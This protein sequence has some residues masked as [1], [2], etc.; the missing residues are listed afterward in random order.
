ME[1][2]EPLTNAE[3]LLLT[4]V[5][6]GDTCDF[7]GG[8]VI[9]STEVAEWGDDRRIRG[10]VLKEL[11][12]G[13]NR[14]GVPAGT[15]I[16]LRGAVVAGDLFGFDGKTLPE[17]GMEYCRFDGWVSFDGAIF[18]GQAGFGCA[19]FS[20]DV[21]FDGTL[22]KGDVSFNGATFSGDT[23][24]DGATFNGRAYFTNATFD[25]E[26]WLKITTFTGWAT[27]DEVTFNG[28]AWFDRAI[29]AGDA[30]FKEAMFAR[31]ASFFGA[32]V[33]DDARFDGATFT[34]RADF[35]RA[36]A[37]EWNLESVTFLAPDPGPWF[38]FTVLINRATVTVR[39]RI[40]IT[41]RKIDAAWLQAPDGAHLL[42]QSQEVDLSD[43]EFLRR[44]IIAGPAATQ[45][46]RPVQHG[47]GLDE[48]PAAIARRA[49]AAAANERSAER[50][51]ELAGSPRR[52]R[53]TSLAR[54]N[55]GE[56]V[57]SDVALDECEFAGA[58]GLDRLR[59]DEGCSFQR[60]PRWFTRRRMIVEEIRWR[61]SH[62]RVGNNASTIEAAPLSALEIAGIYR[63]LRKGLEDSKNEPEAADF[64]YGEM[65][66]RRLVGRKPSAVGADGTRERRSLVEGALLGGYWALSGYGLRAWRA[67]TALTMLI[68]VAA[69]LYTSPTFAF[70]TPPPA[71]IATISPATGAVTFAAQPATTASFPTALKYSAGESISLLQLRSAPALATRGPGT[72]LDFV[73]RLAGPVLLAFAVLALRGRTK[74]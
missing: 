8:A 28:D 4:A 60:T 40:S 26:A 53:V 47:T 45:K 46:V 73:L 9:R 10:A 63:N 25:G 18:A 51:K 13:E 23:W 43:S 19:I 69:C 5:R 39:S 34:G 55:V 33:I 1:E 52:C 37:S 35:D 29:F 61:K 54:A 21:R 12:S 70:E 27:F 58:H 50:A 11:L 2:L 65:E 7:S 24:F 32:T 71:Q 42:V 30:W 48:S 36:L 22:F 6:D 49:V 66:M 44:S 64:Y 72:V 68:L 74:R 38:G 14:W 16:Q 67:V 3:L 59:I 20:R 57:L 31:D 56:L 17:V 15:E 62:T 41:A